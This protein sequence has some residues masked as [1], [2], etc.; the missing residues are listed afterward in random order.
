MN[1]GR[2]AFE[3][4]VREGIFTERIGQDLLGVLRKHHLRQ[5]VVVERCM[6]DGKQILPEPQVLQLIEREW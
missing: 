1:E 3:P 4:D 6:R 2:S 5:I